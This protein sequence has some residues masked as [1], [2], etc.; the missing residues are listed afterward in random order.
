MMC[1]Q[2]SEKIVRILT[3]A[4]LANRS[5]DAFLALTLEA[6]GVLVDV[7]RSNAGNPDSRITYH[8]PPEFLANNPTLVLLWKIFVSL[9]LSLSR[10][11]D[12]M[13][14]IY[15]VPHLYLAYLSSVISRRPLV[16]S[17]IAGRIEFEISGRL[18]QKLNEMIARRARL[19]IVN[20]NTTVEYLQNVGLDRRKIIRYR[21]LNLIANRHFYT[22]NIEKTLD[23]VVVSM[24]LPDKHIDVF[25][26]IV[27]KL[28]ET[29]PNI[30]AGIVGS[31]PLRESLEEYSGLRGLS[32]NIT[33]YGFVSSH[34]ELNR[35]LNSAQIFV[36]NSSHE[37]GP[38]SI[39]EAMNAG[40]CCV[41]SRV[42]EVSL[43]IT[44]GHNGFIVNRYDDVDTYANL[45]RNLLSNPET[46][47]EM[48]SNAAD[49][50][51]QHPMKAVRFWRALVRALS[52]ART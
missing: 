4:G 33:F 40:I 17:V 16:Y 5:L 22:L 52:Q 25:I 14:A 51:N 20:E 9:K 43:R 13:H 44:H 24:L 34:E 36:L 21:F 10:Q 12:V 41:A 11:F 45:L 6:D 2:M 1:T 18:V 47:R 15:G 49:S 30:T 19:V 42:G 3:F 50:R 23:L 26:D 27:D 29:M 37:G 7:V 38:F 48:Q 32:K 28:R 46:L 39:V 31:G 8:C 35:I